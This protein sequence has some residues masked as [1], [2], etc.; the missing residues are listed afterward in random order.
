MGA[1]LCGDTVDDPEARASRRA[2]SRL[3]IRQTTFDISPF[4]S[5]FTFHLSPESLS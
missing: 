2:I 4:L 3:E 5:F 1:S